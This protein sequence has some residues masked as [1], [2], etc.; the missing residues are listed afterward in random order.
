MSVFQLK[1]GHFGSYVIEFGILF[2]THVFA[3]YSDTGL[4]DD[5]GYTFL[6]WGWGGSPGSPPSLC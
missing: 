6:L 4:L 5:G 3:G 2:K 1:P